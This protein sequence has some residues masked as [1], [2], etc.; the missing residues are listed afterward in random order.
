MAR[1]AIITGAAKGLG[2]ACAERFATDG[3]DLALV[4]A[5]ADGLAARRGLAARGLR[6]S[7]GRRR[8]P[9]A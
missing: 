6:R 1:V 4:D 9:R 2:L 8:H 5:D 3:Y 7:G